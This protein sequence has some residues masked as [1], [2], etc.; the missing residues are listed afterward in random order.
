[1]AILCL[2]VYEVYHLKVNRG[3]KNGLV[4]VFLLGGLAVIINIVRLKIL[5][6]I[7]Q[8]GIAA[9]FPLETNEANIWTIVEP[10]IRMVSASIPHLRPLIAIIGQVFGFRSSD[11]DS[12]GQNKFYNI[13]SIV[14]IGG[15]ARSGLSR[16]FFRTTRG[17]AEITT[18]A[19]ERL[20]DAESG[21]Q[22]ALDTIPLKTVPVKQ[23]G[24]IG[25]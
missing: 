11:P 3:E 22:D 15:S 24:D 16:K 8:E 7:M 1:M 14:T 10:S 12:N 25:A 17:E 4:V 9:D 18:S 2:P 23:D 19:F 13:H 5:I 6:D 21:G 20:P